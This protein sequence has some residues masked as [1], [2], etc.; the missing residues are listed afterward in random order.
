MTK[1]YMF[2]C[3]YGRNRSQTAKQL[4]WRLANQKGIDA[5]V[6]HMAL[7]PEDTREQE[8]R[9]RIKLSTFQYIIAMTPEIKEV[10]VKRYSLP[11]E[12]V[13]AWNV[14]DKYK[15][16][17]RKEREALEILLTPLVKDLLEIT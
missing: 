2:V 13:T 15:I 7:Y 11:E 6:E 9:E 5:H 14:P 10:L 1:S 3:N 8:E 16:K 17:R 4:L 12:R